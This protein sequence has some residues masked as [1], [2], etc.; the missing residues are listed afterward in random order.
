MKSM[1][2]ISHTGRMPMCAAPAAA[3][4]IAASEIGVSI[5]R[6][7]PKRSS[8]PSVTLN[9]PPYAPMSSPSMKTLA[10]RSISSNS[11]WR[12]ASRYVVSAIEG[13][14]AR[15]AFVP[16]H[17]G[18]HPASIPERLGL[19]GIGV[20]A[21]QRVVRLR[22]RR[23]I[24]HVRRRIDFR[25]DALIDPRQFR[26][27][28]T[29]GREHGTVAVERVILRLPSLNLSLGDVRLVVVLRVSLATIRDQLDERDALAAPRA[30]HGASGDVVRGKHVV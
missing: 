16:I 2:C 12:I 24:R 6:C 18:G 30:I 27:G 13:P 15:W 9:A 26:G 21:T 19:R 3:P 20:D 4:T 28:N 8:N 29:L 1:N 5:T 10:S 17:R 11:A 25:L 22:H 7:A 14:P 23:R